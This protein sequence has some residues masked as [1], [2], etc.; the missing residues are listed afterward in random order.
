MKEN[1][2]LMG[3]ICGAAAP[4]ILI[5]FVSLAIISNPSFSWEDNALSDLGIS[6]V[7]AAYFNGGVFISGALLLFFSFF[8]LSYPRMKN[9]LRIL[10][11]ISFIS[12]SLIGIFTLDYPGEHTIVAVTF[13]MLTPA[14]VAVYGFLEETKRR[15]NVILAASALSY[16]A[17]A[18]PWKGSGI[19]L[20]EVFSTLPILAFCFSYGTEYIYKWR[21]GIS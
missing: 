21:K 6:D 15:R 11:A 2:M 20:P 4:A 1:R 5:L 9:A 13:F 7:S 19:A 10:F 8:G 14:V 16:I 17:W 18:L 12:L 3:N